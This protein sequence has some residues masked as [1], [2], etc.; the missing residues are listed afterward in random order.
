MTQGK[1]I[2]I[3]GPSAVGKSTITAEVQKQLPNVKRIVTYTNRA[4]RPTEKDGV[5]YNFISA[6]DFKEKIDRDFFVEWAMVYNVYK[7][8]SLQ[9]I[10]NALDCGE[11]IVLVT[12]IQ[13]MATIK[14]KL[15][16]AQLIFILPESI[17]Q[18]K[19]RLLARPQADPADVKI[20]LSKAENEIAK[21]KELCDFF[22]INRENQ[23]E[24]TI[25]EI[26]NII[27]DRT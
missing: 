13:G 16:Q 27:N 18:L 22:V 2:I 26:L 5:D 10:N 8:T 24:N 3:S 14:N 11:N 12:D 4:P 21:A 25:A 7:G 23:Q 6:E 15:P 20:R 17:D 9:D 1:L 19:N